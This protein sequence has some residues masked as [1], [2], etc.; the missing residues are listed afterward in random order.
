MFERLLLI[1]AL[2]IVVALVWGCIRLWRAW[3][4]RALARETPFAG[5][6]PA[7]KPAVVGFSTPGCIECRTRQAPAL[8]QLAATLGDAVT[9]RTLSAPDYPQLI[10]RLGILTAPATVVLDATGVVRYVNLGFT[11]AATLAAQIGS[12]DHL[13]LRP[14]RDAL[15]A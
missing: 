10:D 11:D 2:A 14:R 7:G 9:V 15:A 4:I 1:V 5:I 6:I 8:A 3:K 12:V 13:A